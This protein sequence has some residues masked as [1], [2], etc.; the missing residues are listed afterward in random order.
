MEKI[1]RIFFMVRCDQTHKPHLVRWDIC[2]L[3]K[4]EGGFGIKRRPRRMNDVFLMKM[5]WNLII[6]LDDLLFKVLNSKYGRNKSLR[7]TLNYQPCDYP[8]WKALTGI[9]DQL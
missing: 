7:V 2:C 5:L 1:Q 9:W 6:K 3:P 8:L 4:N